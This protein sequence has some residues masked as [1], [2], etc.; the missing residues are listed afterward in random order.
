MIITKEQ[1]EVALKRI[2][3]LMDSAAGSPEGEE[4]DRLVAQV[5]RYEEIRWPVFQKL[6]GRS[7]DNRH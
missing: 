2:A 5:E 6:T 3:E 4:L 7:G 1:Y